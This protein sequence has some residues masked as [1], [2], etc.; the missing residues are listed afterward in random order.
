MHLQYLSPGW[1]VLNT[2]YT[3]TQ[4]QVHSS[5]HIQIEAKSKCEM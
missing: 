5:P 3:R 2:E 1:A 4:I